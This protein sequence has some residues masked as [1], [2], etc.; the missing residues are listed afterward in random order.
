MD[1]GRLHANLHRHP[2][3]SRM[4][5]FDLKLSDFKKYTIRFQLGRGHP[6][7]I[8]RLKILSL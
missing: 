6:F 3:K 8:G 7:R 2:L 5:V 4:A 1:G